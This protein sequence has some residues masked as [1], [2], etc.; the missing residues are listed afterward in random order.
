MCHLSSPFRKNLAKWK[1]MLSKAK[2]DRESL[3]QERIAEN[4]EDKNSDGSEKSV[5]R[6]SSIDEKELVSNG[7]SDEKSKRPTSGKEKVKSAGSKSRKQSAKQR[8]S[9]EIKKN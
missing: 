1:D 8:K 5:S 4:K 3:E 7:E 6:S 2:D 9:A